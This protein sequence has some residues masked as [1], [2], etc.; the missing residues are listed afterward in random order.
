MTRYVALLVVTLLASCGNRSGCPGCRPMSPTDGVTTYCLRDVAGLRAALQ[1]AI[2]AGTDRARE[3]LLL[4]GGGANGAWGAGVLNGWTQ[5]GTRPAAFQVVTGVSTGALMSTFAFLGSKYDAVLEEAYI[6]A[7]DRAIYRNRCPLALPF[8]NSLKDTAPLSRLIEKYVTTDVLAEVADAYSHERRRL[9]VGTVDLDEGIFCAWDMG[10]LAASSE[11]KRLEY[12]RKILLA[13]AAIP[14]VFPPVDL[15]GRLHADGG[16]RLQLFTQGVIEPILNTFMRASAT[17]RHA[18]PGAPAEGLPMVHAIVNG[19]VV[20]DRD[21]VQDRMIP[22]GSRAIDILLTE[23]IFGSL[24]RAWAS[25]GEQGT[26]LPKSRF[27]VSHVPGDLRLP[28]STEFNPC[29]MRA[30]YDAGLRAGRAGQWVEGVPP[31]GASALP[32]SDEKPPCEKQCQS[33]WWY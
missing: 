21:C 29:C 31:S 8:A 4:S 9:F 26:P 2:D 30:L 19:K 5:S 10:R 22:I 23:G 33:H 27:L 17:R 24:Y 14:V 6:H 7:D 1:P 25:T 12:F 18:A 15:G 28:P 3:L 32:C 11:P 20:A 16:V 13:S